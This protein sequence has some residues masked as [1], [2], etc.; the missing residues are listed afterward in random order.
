MNWT[1]WK[2][3]FERKFQALH[4]QMFKTDLEFLPKCDRKHGGCFYKFGPNTNEAKLTSYLGFQIHKL[5]QSSDY[6]IYYNDEVDGVLK[7]Q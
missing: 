4:Y 5:G 1:H 2:D 7:V 6:S 3:L